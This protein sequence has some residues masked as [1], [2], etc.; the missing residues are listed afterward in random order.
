MRG[1]FPWRVF[2]QFQNIALFPPKLPSAL[3]QFSPPPRVSPHLNHQ[4]PSSQTSR[5]LH[6]GLHMLHHLIHLIPRQYRVALHITHPSGS[7]WYHI[8]RRLPPSNLDPAPSSESRITVRQ[9][10][11][12]AFMDKRSL[13][14]VRSRR[15]DLS[16][17]NSTTN[18]IL[19]LTTHQVVSS[20]RISGT[21]SNV[22]PFL[23]ES[24]PEPGLPH[25]GPG[26]VH[27]P[28]LPVEFCR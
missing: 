22:G 16:S 17:S 24:C 13:R 11:S 12:M 20:V 25:E 8:Q 18:G 21:P 28:D 7:L 10:V 3:P 2:H 9:R 23:I 19:N 1:M 14:V 5:R 4:T 15:I 26:D 6:S 27:T